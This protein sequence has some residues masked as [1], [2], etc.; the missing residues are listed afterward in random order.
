M[1]TACTT[2]CRHYQHAKQLLKVIS[3][4]KQMLKQLAKLMVPRQGADHGAFMLLVFIQGS[5]GAAVVCC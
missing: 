1:K 5:S 2:S 3:F 4:C